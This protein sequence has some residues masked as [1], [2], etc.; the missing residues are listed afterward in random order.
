MSRKETGPGATLRV[1]RRA[2]GDTPLPALNFDWNFL[3]GPFVTS[4]GFVFHVKTMPYIPF[5]VKY[6]RHTVA[7]LEPFLYTLPLTLPGAKTS[8]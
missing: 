1:G 4:Q 7:F 6:Y 3:D 8:P 2:F 5:S